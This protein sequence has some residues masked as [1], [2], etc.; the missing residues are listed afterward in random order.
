MDTGVVTVEK[1]DTEEAVACMTMG[2]ASLGN[3]SDSNSSKKAT[4][5]SGFQTSTH[6]DNVEAIALKAMADVLLAGPNPFSFQ[7]P[8]IANGKII[9]DIP[10]S[11]K[12]SNTKRDSLF[13]RGSMDTNLAMVT[14]DPALVDMPR[15]LSDEL[16]SKV[17]SMINKAP[18]S[19]E[20]QTVSDNNTNRN[21][22][23]I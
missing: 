5:D 16:Y 12:I 20:H 10:P 22:Q 4:V 23:N 17:G 3:V 11:L 21:S 8:V 6:N 7:A 18:S 13:K 14:S 9:V 15:V 19:S 1:I 2:G